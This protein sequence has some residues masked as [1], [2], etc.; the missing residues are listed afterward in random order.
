MMDCKWLCRLA[1][2]HANIRRYVV[3][4]FGHKLLNE[5]ENIYRSTLIL[6]RLGGQNSIHLI[7]HV[8]WPSQVDTW[9][10]YDEMIGDDYRSRKGDEDYTK[11]RQFE[12]EQEEEKRQF[13]KSKALQEGF[14]KYTLVPRKESYK[15]ETAN[16]E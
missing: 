6:E 7:N 16:D 4:Q 3:R 2:I 14:R 12:E 15:T 1:N 9:N 11:W 8:P 13:L 10:L 5:K